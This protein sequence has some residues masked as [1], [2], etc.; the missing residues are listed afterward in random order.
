MLS[1]STFSALQ[2]STNLQKRRSRDLPSAREH[3]F[4]STVKTLEIRHLRLAYGVLW[5]GST[6]YP[7]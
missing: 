7:G 2:A 4:L 1:F 3:E 5:Q 6:Q